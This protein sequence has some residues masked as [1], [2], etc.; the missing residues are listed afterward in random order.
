MSLLV[1]ICNINI[2]KICLTDQI[3]SAFSLGCWQ[4]RETRRDL[5]V[6]YRCRSSLASCRSHCRSRRLPGCWI[7]TRT[8][9]NPEREKDSP[10][11]SE[12]TKTPTYNMVK[13]WMWSN[14][15]LYNIH[16][17]TCQRGWNVWPRRWY[18]YWACMEHDW[19]F[20]APWWS[21]LA[22]TL[23]SPDHSKCW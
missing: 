17:M 2:T 10:V 3:C 11:L 19:L 20:V 6:R 5:A 21:Q 4:R 9:G 14:K 16:I 1:Y 13:W 12:C 22:L 15:M 8:A 18:S 23:R 7:E